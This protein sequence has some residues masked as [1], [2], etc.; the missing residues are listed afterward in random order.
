[1]HG[2]SY[3]VPNYFR[4]LCLTRGISFRHY[5]AYLREDYLLSRIETLFQSVKTS[6]FRVLSVESRTKDGGV[7]V[8]F[9]YEPGEDEQKTL[10]NILKTLQDEAEE[11]GG[12]P[13]WLGVRPQAGHIWLVKGKPWREVEQLVYL[14]TMKL[15]RFRGSTGFEQIFFSN[16]QGCLR[17]PGYP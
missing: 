12:I 14:K 5:V 13:T 8:K 6:G 10:H 4:A 1:V 2:S 9:N 11:Q 7:F 3:Y 17:W 16:A 15:T